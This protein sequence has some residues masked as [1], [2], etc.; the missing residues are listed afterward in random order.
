MSTTERIVHPFPPV[1]GKNPHVLIL[2]TFPS[3]T[4][5]KLGGYYAHPQ[6]AFWR[7]I[8]DVCNKPSILAAQKAAPDW[9][10]PT[11]QDWDLRYRTLRQYRFALWDVVDSC[12]RSGGSSDSTLRNIIPNPIASFLHDHPTIVRVI[13]NGRKAE[14]LYN[15]LITPSRASWYAPSTSAACAM[16][17]RRKLSLW[18][19]VLRG[20]FP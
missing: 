17:Y 16:T 3:A 12:T 13:L 8:S 15:R 14:S 19:R 4:S 18:T 2:G 20:V 1:V 9:L 11:I 10:G 7:I 5:V 6:N